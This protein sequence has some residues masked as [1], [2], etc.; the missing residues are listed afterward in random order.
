MRGTIRRWLLRTKLES[1]RRPKCLNI[2][3][4]I[5]IF[6]ILHSPSQSIAQSH[7]EED[8]TLRL[9]S[10]FP[11]AGQRGT[12]V[13][14]EI[15]G[16]RLD[17]AHTVWF[18]T[19]GSLAA[20]LL[21]VVEVKADSNGSANVLQKK[22]Q[23]SPL[24]RAIVEIH[25]E[26]T[27]RAGVYPL[28]LVSPR[29]LSNAI[30]FRVTDEAVVV[31]SP[32]S[33]QTLDRAQ[34]VALPAMI[35][36]KLEKPGELDYYSFQASKGEEVRVEALQGQ[37][38]DE[39]VALSKLAPEVA[40]YRAGGSWFDP[41]RPR[42][43]LFAEERT[44]DL[45]PERS[46]GTYQFSEDGQYFLQ[47]SDLFGQG[48]SDCTYQVLVISVRRKPGSVAQLEP[49]KPDWSERS[50]SRRLAE[51][52]MMSLESRAVL[53]GGP[54]TQAKNVSSVQGSSSSSTVERQPRQPISLSTQPASFVEREP[55][56]S[57]AQAEAISIP[58]VIEGRIQ[59]P[60]DLDSFKF[61]VEPGQKLAFEI[62]TPDAMP[63]YFNPRLGVVDSQNQELFSNVERRLSAFNNNADPQVY[64]KDVE[65]KV[66]YTFERG[67]EYVLQVRDITSRYGD[68]S[69][70]YKIL[71]RPQIPHVGEVSITEGAGSD[72]E[73]AVS[74]INLVRGE[75]RRLTLTASYEEGFTGDL[76]F[77]FTGLP[78]G[79]Q[80]FPAMQFTD[81]RRPLEVTQNP[82]L[83]AP[84]QQRT[85][86][87]LMASSDAKLSSEPRIVQLHCRL[88]A[89]GK[90]GPNLLVREIPL[91]VVEDQKK[92]GEKSGS[93]T[94]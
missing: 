27:T 71:V 38:L 57:A 16:N 79:V 36:G 76:A 92:D 75:P 83:I 61:K 82:D 5:A 91:M 25:I 21:R 94:E 60:G 51:D 17:G 18:D 4:S 11:T 69:Y 9:L 28:R 34:P 48:C 88:M 66:T 40:L 29:G 58:V 20:R 50:F 85:T 37:A 63:P 14:A 7:P 22:K 10:I 39:A 53:G 55:N 78:E 1:G 6:L 12:S 32:G 65:P 47:V 13:Q 31:E 87:E 54:T 15:R 70:R 62:E 59:H 68:P 73:K 77:S 93:E 41:H 72:K 23:A 35:S 64:L 84:K 2:G 33:H 81:E 8:N 80:A 90:L 86:I 45:M 46:G 43:V 49:N 3:I 30:S 74:V 52:W 24:Y 56:D 26:P 42:R 67:S 89:D 44:S 19:S